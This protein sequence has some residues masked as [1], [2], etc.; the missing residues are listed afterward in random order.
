M[1]NQRRRRQR[2][3][4]YIDGYNLYYGLQ[5]AFGKKYKWLDLQGLS[6]K[7]LEPCV[8]L[9]KVKYFTTIAKIDTDSKKRQQIYL[10]ALDAHCKKLEISYGRFLS[11]S[12]KC[13]NCGSSYRTY[14]E[15]KTDVSIA[16]RVL[17]DAYLDK[18]DYCYIVSGDSDLVPLLEVVKETCPNKTI[19]IAHPPKRKSDELCTLAHKW[20][21]VSE[22]KIRHSLLPEGVLSESGKELSRPK[23]WI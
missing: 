22:Q 9:V 11:K 7:L 15:K 18:Y 10:K 1:D 14:E 16:C 8:E 13:K 4:A 12:R 6:S 20:L 19:V 23:E 5:Q 21:A 17:K 3:I 2:G